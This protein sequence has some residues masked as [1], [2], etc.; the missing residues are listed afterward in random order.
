[1][2]LADPSHCYGCQ[3]CVNICPSN[4]INMQVNEL[5]EILPG[6]DIALC[7]KCGIC[8]KY[9]PVLNPIALHSTKQCFA[10]WSKAELR[11]CKSASGSI[12]WRIG[13]QILGAKGTAFGAAF[14]NL[15]LQHRRAVSEDE[16]ELF[17]GSKYVQSD[18]GNSFVEVQKDLNEGRTVVFF[19]TPCQNAGLKCFLRKDY[20]NLFTVD[21][22][23]H[24]IVPWKHFYE[25]V[26]ENLSNVSNCHV[27]F[28]DRNGYLFRIIRNEKN[29]YART[30]NLDYYY[31][32]FFQRLN[33]RE[34]CYSCPYASEKRVGDIT[35]GDF[36][37][38]KRETMR[39]AK[40]PM[41]ISAVLIN[42]EQGKKL[43][44]M[45]APDL[46]FEEREIAEAVAGNDQL[47]FPSRKPFNRKLFCY[48]YAWGGFAGGVV[49]SGLP[50][51]LLYRKIRHWGGRILRA[52]KV[53]GA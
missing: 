14:N 30:P 16:L 29:I 33:F 46:E 37:G 2:A 34:C 49:C 6:I 21:L 43:W 1:M 23:C 13:C 3:A 5:G 10:A 12:A 8:E 32:A 40:L 25:H 35:I 41:Y 7:S 26:R 11:N 27:V 17:C 22:V 15:H 31:M 47:K 36:W 24:G 44:G 28:R 38:L 42:T 4:A 45:V 39:H 53:T 20:K 52:L 19:G 50:F 18:I 48:G 9:C 51:Y